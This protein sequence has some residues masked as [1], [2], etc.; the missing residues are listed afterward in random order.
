MGSKGIDIR[1]TIRRPSLLPALHCSAGWCV[2]TCR[3]L[4]E[5]LSDYLDGELENDARAGAEEH[6]RECRNCGIVLSTTRQMLL[7][8]RMIGHERLPDALLSR[9]FS[10]LKETFA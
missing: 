4:L 6:L 5:H 10:R 1:G 7:L 9:L 3:E 2:M 8:Y